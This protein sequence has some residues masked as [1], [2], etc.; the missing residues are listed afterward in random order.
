MNK[1]KVVID[2]N[3]LVSA[4]ITG[5]GN[6]AKIIDMVLDEKF[7]FYCNEKIRQEYRKVLS[8]P[9]FK[10]TAE[11]QA[12][13]LT[14]LDSVRVLLIPTIHV[15]DIAFTDESDRV[16]YD[17]AKSCGA[18]LITGNT[19]HYP[20]EPFIMIPAEFLSVFNNV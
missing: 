14:G 10:L 1:A 6:P 16:F 3:V 13:F 7:E 15:S 20:H 9:K 4:A 19:K 5:G 11:Q 2:T 8:R 18:I 17:V 12:F